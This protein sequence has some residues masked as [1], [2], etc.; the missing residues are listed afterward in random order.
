[1]EYLRTKDTA[2][3]WGIPEG[4]V[5]KPCEENRVNGVQHLDKHGRSQKRRLNL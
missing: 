3:K 5:Q 4:R 1:M 2:L